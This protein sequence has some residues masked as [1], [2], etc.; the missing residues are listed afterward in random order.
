MFDIHVSRLKSKMNDLVESLNREFV[1]EEPETDNNVEKVINP[2]NFGHG[3]NFKTVTIL[4][5]VMT[6]ITLIV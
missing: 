5:I 6:W 4:I 3:P 1:I 2:N